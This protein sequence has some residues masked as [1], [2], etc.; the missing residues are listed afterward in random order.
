M[1]KLLVGERSVVVPGEKIAE[2]L[3]YL[4]AHGAYRKD[5]HIL[6]GKLGLLTVDGRAVKI[7]PLSGRYMPKRNDVIIGKV[8]DVMI[9]GW[10]MD[11]NCAYSAMLSMKDATSD[12]IARGADLT[13]FF[14]LEDYVVVKIVN[15]TSQKLVDLTTKGPGLRK[16]YGGRVITVN[17]NKVPRII[18]KQGSMV[19]LIKNATGC[20]IIVGQNGIVWLQ[21]EPMSEVIAIQAIKKIE[22]ESH[23]SGLT[24]RVT[25]FLEKSCGKIEPRESSEEQNDEQSEEAQ[26]EQ[27]EQ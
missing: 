24:E 8:I 5:D 6:A 20:K 13:Q 27:Q 9:S 2:G 22:E 16:L 1:G 26:E 18:G 21:G 17:C 11:I 23:I 15:V 7:I 14:N 4:P 19:S 12:F 25:E 10:R 3:D